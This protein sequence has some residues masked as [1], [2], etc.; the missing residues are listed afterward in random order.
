MQNT[1][2]PIRIL[3]FSSTNASNDKSSSMKTNRTPVLSSISSAFRGCYRRRFIA[4]LEQHDTQKASPS[5]QEYFP[6]GTTSD[7]HSYLSYFS[8]Q[9]CDLAF[10]SWTHHMGEIDL[11]F[12]TDPYNQKPPG[13][14]VEI[15]YA[16]YKVRHHIF[17]CFD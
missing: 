15:F 3:L 14:D 9:E 5:G 1:D 13:I 10:G 7:E 16:P 6:Q 8:S 11:N 2:S 12:V 4:R 17:F